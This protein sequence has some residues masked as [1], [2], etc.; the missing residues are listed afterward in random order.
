[1]VVMTDTG[2]VANDVGWVMQ[3]VDGGI[4]AM[5]VHT[6]ICCHAYHYH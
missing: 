2:D 1:M 5:V 3:V 6:M 4:V